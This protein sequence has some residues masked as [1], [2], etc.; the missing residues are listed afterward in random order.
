MADHYIVMGDILKSRKY[1][2]KELMRDFKS[3]VS[4]CNRKLAE[5]ILSP[6]TITLGDEF[7]GVSKSL[8]WCVQSLLYLEESTL[9]KGLSFALR[10]VVHYGRIDTPLNRKVAYGMVGRGLTRAR[11]LL[12]TKRRGPQRFLF[13]L[14]DQN[15][16]MQL[17]RLFGVMA[18]LTRDW[19]RKDVDLIFEMLSTDDNAAIGAKYGKNRSQI[20]KRRRN[21]HVDDYKALRAIVIQLSQEESG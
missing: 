14:P 15:L 3:M 19:K 11:E 13:D 9:R 10:Y 16:A 4:S 18:S 17:S 8:H 6:Y 21:M 2:G 12:T 7:Q 5:G 20:W 1:D